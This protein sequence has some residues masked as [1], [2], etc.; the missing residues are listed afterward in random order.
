MSNALR[1]TEDPPSVSR[2]QRSLPRKK[3]RKWRLQRED[4]ERDFQARPGR[5]HADG[6]G[7][8]EVADELIGDDLLDEDLLDENSSGEDT[9][10]PAN[11]EGLIEALHEVFRQPPYDITPPA[12]L[13]LN[14][15]VGSILNE[16]RPDENRSEWRAAG[17]ET[18]AG[19]INAD[20]IYDRLSGSATKEIDPSEGG[21]GVTKVADVPAT[22]VSQTET[23]KT[24]A[25]RIGPETIEAASA[26]G[27]FNGSA[28]QV[29]KAAKHLF[30]TGDIGPLE[31]LFS[32]DGQTSGA[33]AG[34]DRRAIEVKSSETPTQ[35]ASAPQPPL[36]TSTGGLSGKIDAAYC[37]TRVPAVHG[38]GG[39]VGT[40]SGELESVTA[41]SVTRGDPRD[42]RELEALSEETIQYLV[43]RDPLGTV[44]RLL[45]ST[46][47]RKMCVRWRPVLSESQ[48]LM[49][50]HQHILFSDM[51]DEDWTYSGDCT[52]VVFPAGIVL[53]SFGYRSRQHLHGDAG[54]N[55]GQLFD[56]YRREVTGLDLTDWNG[57]E[58]KGRVV[59]SH[60][61]P[62]RIIRKAKEAKLSPGKGEQWFI[63]GKE[64]RADGDDIARERDKRFERA[65]AQD[66]II[67]PPETTRRMQ[68]YLNGLR[69][70][71]FSNGAYGVFKEDK[72]E[73]ARQAARTVGA[74]EKGRDR[75]LEKLFLIERYPQPVYLCCGRFPR[76]K[77]DHH[78]Q[79]MNLPTLIRRS[80]YTARDRELDLSKAH[81]GSY[82]PVA[83][84][85]G[86]AVP[87]LERHLQANLE[88]DTDLLEEGDLWT[89][90]ASTIRCSA[91][92]DMEALRDAVKGAYSIVYGKEK[93]G[94]P[95]Q[96]LKEYFRL[97]G[98]FHNTTDPIKPLLSHPL[99]EEI[100]GTRNELEAIINAR[101]GLEDVNG[102]FIPLS[103]WN[104]TKDQENRWRGVL[105]YVNASYEQ[106]LMGA[107]FDVARKEIGRSGNTRFWI[108]LYQADGFTMRVRSDASAARQVSR[109][110]DA[111]D[112]KAGELGVPTELEVDHSTH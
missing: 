56:I 71:R 105:A 2:W 3:L 45:T 95:Y 70:Q 38:G 65:E 14:L 83:K 44:P 46:D 40:T 98:Y 8:G 79:A 19:R 30:S 64:T 23:Y 82:V 49:A 93:G 101:G 31:Y 66:P 50:A 28:A 69:Q 63:S 106:E 110:Q 84:R 97:T 24:T 10:A 35:F 75:G 94:L 13:E 91:L 108:W 32:P 59:K 77:A 42:R 109:L 43:D 41:E 107:A 21:I 9:S 57:R 80:V 25:Y 99:M 27:H 60:G 7:P 51:R 48:S 22:L 17:H 78:N 11:L 87:V 47:L 61:I 89:E 39:I 67:D 20:Q 1:L 102:R 34:P 36:S 33:D 92:R 4:R 62:D 111:V 85:E 29:T 103:A 72:M 96:I 12:Y 15:V 100:L 54:A 74:R 68:A 86:L 73:N 52:G 18:E 26:L 6:L 112:E 53:A 5:S 90:L 81:L 58:G 76:L 88:G 16:N 104:E 55:T 37:S